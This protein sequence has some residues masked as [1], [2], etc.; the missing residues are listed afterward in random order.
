ML[1]FLMDLM[2]TL[3]WTC[4]SII[5]GTTSVMKKTYIDK[6]GNEILSSYRVLL[7]A[8]YKSSGFDSWVVMN[9]LVEGKTELKMIKTVRGLI[10]LSFRCYF[11]IV[12]T[13]EVPQY[14]KFTCTKSH[15]KGSLKKSVE[16]TDFNSNFSK[17][18]LNTRFL[19]KVILLI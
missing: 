14:I 1:A 18:K 4:L 9:S 13:V 10:S 5:Q 11:K 3:S 7:V 15:V 19:I 16:I 2:E 17:E 6:D 8:A 12:N